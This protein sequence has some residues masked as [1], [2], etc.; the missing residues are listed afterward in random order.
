M[1]TI[2]GTALADMGVILLQGAYAEL[3]APAETKDFVENDDPTKHG[4]EID[5]LLSPKLKKRDVTLRFLV[6]GNSE[7]DFL[8]KYH[9]FLDLLYSG[10]IELEV[11]DLGA[12]FRLI[13]RAKTKY[14]NYRL[15][16]CEMAVKFTEPDPTN[17]AL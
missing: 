8:T 7:E 6:K 12:C 11:P 9:V 10:H 13:Y 15:N 5:T 1:I 14:A 3:M 4:V 17:R 2:N 16:A